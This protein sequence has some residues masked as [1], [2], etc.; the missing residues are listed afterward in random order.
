MIKKWI[1]RVL[2]SFSSPNAGPRHQTPEAIIEEQKA[3][4]I[5]T[6]AYRD[7]W[8]EFYKEW[9]DPKNIEI[10][11]KEWEAQKEKA[12]SM[13]KKAR[14]NIRRE[15]GIP[16]EDPPLPDPLPDHLKGQPAS[17]IRAMLRQEKWV[18]DRML[19]QWVEK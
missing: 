15:L 5:K 13:G 7:K 2:S 16:L 9:S 11:R 17:T 6:S 18:F 14:E 10:R 19:N 8:S 1:I 12:D 4:R 3:W